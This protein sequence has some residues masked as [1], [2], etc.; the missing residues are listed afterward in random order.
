MRKGGLGFFVEHGPGTFDSGSVLAISEFGEEAGSRDFDGAEAFHVRGGLLGV[1]EA[2][3]VFDGEGNQA[4]QRD[5]RCIAL[6][7]KHGF[8]KE[9]RS[10]RNAVES[11]NKLAVAI[12]FEGMGNAGIVHRDVGFPHIIG[13]PCAGLAGSR[14]DR[15]AC[16][17]GLEIG[18]DANDEFA[19]ANDPLQ[20]GSYLKVPRI[21][22][23]PWIG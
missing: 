10:E 19:G 20:R 9:G 14:L 18:I 6:L 12:G 21:E 11:A 13:D 7:V 2:E 16:D 3:A 17:D 22:D 15:A 8:S 1:D 4:C 23:H 5:F